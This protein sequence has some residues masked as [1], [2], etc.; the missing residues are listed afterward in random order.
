MDISL[1]PA[2]ASPSPASLWAGALDAILRFGETGCP[3]ASRRAADLLERLADNPGTDEA[4]RELCERAARRF[5][6]LPGPP[7]HGRTP[8]L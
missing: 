1:H 3:R 4:L 6:V 2:P 8:D 5:D 7:A